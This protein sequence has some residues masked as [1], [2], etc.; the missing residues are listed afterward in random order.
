MLKQPAVQHSFTNM[1]YI[2][3][4]KCS[5]VDTSIAFGYY[6]LTGVASYMSEERH[7]TILQINDTHGY[8]EPHHEIFWKSGRPT[9]RKV[10]G[11]ARMA[12]LLSQFEVEHPNAVITLDNGDTLHGTFTAMKNN[13]RAMVPILNAM[14]IDAM[15][16]HWEFSYSPAEFQNLTHQLNYPMIAI[17]CFSKDTKT[18]I[19]SHGTIIERKG[20]HIGV[21]GIASNIIDK[22]MP[23]S[24][25]DGVYFTL[26]NEE[27]PN[28][29][30]HLR[31]KERVDLIIVLSHLGYPQ[32]LKLVSEIDGIDVLLS[33]HTHNRL[34][35][36]VV[37]NRT[38]I[39][40]SGS[41][42]SF[43]GKL[44]LKIVNNRV[45]TF[46]HK[47]I[48][49]EEITTPNPAIQ[50]MITGIL[51][52]SERSM[53]DTIVGQTRSTLARWR[54][55]ESTMDNILLQ[56]CQDA[57]GTDLAFSNGWRF[58]APIPP[59][60]VTMND[61]YNIIP[62]NPPI[63]VCEI[64][65]KELWQMMEDNLENTY[66]RDPYRQLGGY[67]KRCLGLTIYFKIENPYRKRIHEFFIGGHPID[68]SK[69]Y[70]ACFLTVQSIP[71]HY[72]TNR[73]DL[74]LTAIDA[75]KQFIQ[76][77]SPVSSTL[78]GTIVPI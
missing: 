64:T 73:R 66:S 52:Q 2:G 36:P 29:I 70:R 19:F 55:L 59:G 53:L 27:L 10:G 31:D 65:G 20:L 6:G 77:H 78:K 68:L 76:K 69:T 25:S 56:A 11:F 40:Q 37:V 44:D 3:N 75:L 41:H 9:T 22:I 61:L 62:N 57:S 13:G 32:D 47:L 18:P 34:Y 48:S 74:H 4:L 58:G 21:I 39:I 12:T 67:V 23:S 15:T 14:A 30:T 46:R 72:G 24:Y 60:N 5:K 33:G 50:D 38:V 16:A 28:Y 51:S 7:L 49:I 71:A 17:N 26:G 45:K 42:A 35:Q 54:S 43:L 63:S 1:V 8:L